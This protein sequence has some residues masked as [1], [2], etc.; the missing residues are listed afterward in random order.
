ME[1]KRAVEVLKA[2]VPKTCKIVEGRYKG[3]FDNWESDM[4]QAIKTA[5]SILKNAEWIPVAERMPDANIRV[6]VTIRH[7]EWIA[8][9]GH[10]DQAR[11]PEWI[12]SCEARYLCGKEWEYSD[13]E[14]EYEV[15]SAF[16]N[17][18]QSG[19]KRF[20]SFDEV[21]AWMPLPEPYRLEVL[22]EAGEEAETGGLMPAM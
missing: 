6:M 12:E 14:C 11:H 1:I 18:G 19:E 22:R 20:Y 9:P 16:S 5:I 7:H 2:N 21:I 3:G 15:T 17:P 10:E 4:G 8:D 13:R